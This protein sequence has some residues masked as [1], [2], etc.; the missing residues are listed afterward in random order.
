MVTRD[1][2]KERLCRNGK[3]HI[4]KFFQIM[5]PRHFFLGFR[6]SENK[7]AESKVIRDRL[8]QVYV[9]LL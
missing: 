8:P 6:I 4:L 9:H 2:I 5:Y 3:Q 7:I 1:M